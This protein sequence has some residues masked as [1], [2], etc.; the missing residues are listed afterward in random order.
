MCGVAISRSMGGRGKHHCSAIREELASYDYCSNC[1]GGSYKYGEALED[2]AADGGQELYLTGT[3]SAWSTFEELVRSDGDTYVGKI[4]LG[5]TLRERFRIVMDKDPRRAIYPIAGRAGPLLRV[6]GPDGLCQGKDWLIDGRR[7]GVPA[8]TVYRVTFEWGA[9]GKSIRW[10]PVKGEAAPEGRLYE[11]R[12]FI[13]GS[14]TAWA[15]MEMKRHPDEPG[16]WEFASLVRS[17]NGATFAFLRD[18]DAT[19][20]IYPLESAPTESSVPVM[21]PGDGSPARDDFQHWR[22][23]GKMGSAVSVTLR[24][25]SGE[26]AVSLRTGEQPEVTWRSPADRSDRFYVVGSFTGWR[27][28]EMLRDDVV[29]GVYRLRFAVGYK[30]C[31]Q[32]QIVVNRNWE[33]RLYPA[34]A[35]A[36][37]GLGVVHGP[38]PQGDGFNWVVS[39]PSGQA[40][41]ILLDLASEDRCGMVTCEPCGSALDGA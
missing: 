11:H 24:V 27:F 13:F 30:D 17:P 16:A 40:M 20:T 2:R 19:Q 23:Q 3:W 26:I 18:N 41:E 12:Y 34:H 39:G 14:L 28:A 9:S 5:E 29:S 21:G 25:D 37:P 7:D 35:S 32:F 15:P 10:E 1:F 36:T 6:V 33:T 22:V 31:D 38:G 4:V 8:G